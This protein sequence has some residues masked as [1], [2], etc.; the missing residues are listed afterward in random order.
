MP[1][2]WVPDSQTTIATSSAYSGGLVF[3]TGLSTAALSQTTAYW[4][5]S[6]AQFNA[7]VAVYGANNNSLNVVRMGAAAVLPPSPPLAAP[8]IRPDAS[9]RISAR[10]KARE[11]LLRFL[12]EQQRQSHDASGGFEVVGKSGSIYRINHGIAGNIERLDRCGRTM[13][14]WCVHPSAALPAEDAML[15][16]LLHLREDDAGLRRIANVT[17][18]PR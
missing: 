15:A 17:R 5:Q 1:W 11:L 12:D 3:Q 7:N 10:A 4:G 13:E 6:L 9:D 8:A 14:R 2:V 18:M 16:Q